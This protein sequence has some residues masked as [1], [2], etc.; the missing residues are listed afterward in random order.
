MNSFGLNLSTQY[1]FTYPLLLLTPVVF[2]LL[3]AAGMFGKRRAIE[4]ASPTLFVDLP[5]SFRQLVRGPLL[6][7]LFT[8]THVCLAIAASRPISTVTVPQEMERR[9]LMLCVDVSDS[10]NTLDFSPTSRS[11]SRFRGV[12]EVI[13]TFIKEKSAERIGLVIFG[14]SAFLQVPLTLDTSMLLST[15]GVLHPG[16]AGNGTAIGDGLGLSIKRIRHI[17]GESKAI[18]LTTD[19]VNNAGSINPVQAAHLAKKF[20]IRIHT[21]GVG[22]PGGVDFDDKILREIAS[23]SGG[24]YFNAQNISELKEVYSAIEKLET[25]S[26]RDPPKT[27]VYEHFWGFALAGLISFLLYAFLQWTWLLLLP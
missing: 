5:P 3:S 27:M 6:F 9:N 24:V 2:F 12:Q 20:G 18:I 16:V 26:D 8:T 13:T 4:V 21:I 15:L 1:S 22:L 14:S 7:L 19:G 11:F 17:K 23:I 10:M 25:T